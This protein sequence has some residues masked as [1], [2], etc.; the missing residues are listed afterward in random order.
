MQIT[1]LNKK[2]S[3]TFLKS[4]VFSNSLLLSLL[5]AAKRAK[6]DKI[7]ISDTNLKFVIANKVVLDKELDAI[8]A[9]SYDGLK[10]ELIISNE[11]S[12]SKHSLKVFQI[13]YDEG[14]VLKTKLKEF[15]SKIKTSAQ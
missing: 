4:A 2:S 14:K 6:R 7:I 8:C 12:I 15:N 10:E 11:N 1:I 9:I 13:N 3:L 5:L